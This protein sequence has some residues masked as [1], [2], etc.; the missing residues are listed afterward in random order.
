MNPDSLTEDKVLDFRK[1]IESTMNYK[2]NLDIG[3]LNF[4]DVET[5]LNGCIYVDNAVRKPKVLLVNESSV[6]LIEKTKKVSSESVRDL[7]RNSYYIDDIDMEKGDVRPS[8]ILN[9]YSAETYNIYENKFIYTVIYFI[10]KFAMDKEKEFRDLDIDMYRKLSY[11]GSTN[12]GS[13]EINVKL[14]VSCKDDSLDALSQELKDKIAKAKDQISKI[15]SYVAAWRRSDMILALEKAKVKLLNPPIKRTNTILKNPNFQE[16]VKLFNFLISYE[17]GKDDLSKDL[18][19]DGNKLLRR[20][21]NHT[22]LFDY[23]TLK[24]VSRT[25]AEQK[26]KVKDSGL[27]LLRTEIRELIDILKDSG[28]KVTK[29]DLMKIL[30]EELK[31]TK[32]NNTANITSNDIKKKFQSSIDDYLER[33]DDYL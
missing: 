14:L 15:K 8:R 9:V 5:V 20:M 32:D 11:V 27:C 31:G 4:D 2:S 25:M 23:A 7:S 30:E 18:N 33:V 13:E 21:V 6:E 1:N 16:S 24:C 22:F 28:Y 3:S 12:I 10:A 17:S 26:D 29:E 19:S